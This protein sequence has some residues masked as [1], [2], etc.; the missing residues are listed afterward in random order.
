VRDY[1]L[2]YLTENPD[3]SE[4]DFKIQVIKDL[5]PKQRISISARL[6][7]AEKKVE[8][9]SYKEWAYFMGAKIAF[10]KE[11]YTCSLI[12]RYIGTKE[13]ETALKF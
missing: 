5:T 9:S 12:Y 4:T 11:D 3:L 7:K 2:E 1:W 13:I 10:E 6:E 8:T